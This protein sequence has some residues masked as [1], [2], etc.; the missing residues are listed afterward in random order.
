LQPGWVVAEDRVLVF[1]G[2]LVD[3]LGDPFTDC[4]LPLRF[5]LFIDPLLF[6]INLLFEGTYPESSRLIL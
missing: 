2:D 1:L 6:P 4:L 5:K 3:E